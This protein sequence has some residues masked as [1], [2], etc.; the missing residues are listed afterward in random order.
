LG[1]SLGL[2]DTVWAFRLALFLQELAFLCGSYLLCRRLF[3]HRAATLFVCIGAIFTVAWHYQ[4]YWSFHVYYLMPFVILFLLRFADGHDVRWLWSA[5]IVFV[6]SLAGNLAYIAP[7]SM[8][9]YLVFGIGL[10]LFL[11]LRR[12][13]LVMKTRS[14]L[15]PMSLCL[16]GLLLLMLWSYLDYAKHSFDGMQ[17]YTNDRG[18]DGRV[19]LDTFLNYGRFFGIKKLWEFI[20]AAPSTDDWSLY[21]GII[22]LVFLAYAIA[23]G[24]KHACFRALIVVSAL[25]ICFSLSSLT[26]IAPVLYYSIPQMSAFRHIAYVLPFIKIPLLLASGFGVDSFI[27]QLASRETSQNDR[28]MKDA[29]W[30]SPAWIGAVF[31]G[32]ILYF[33][34]LVYKDVFPYVAT[35][36]PYDFHQVAL[37]FLVGLLFFLWRPRLQSAA[38]ALLLFYLLEVAS[39]QFSLL[40]S[41][42]LPGMRKPLVPAQATSTAEWLSQQTTA[43]R[44]LFH[45]QPYAF[46]D[47]RIDRE[48]ANGFN[49]YLQL[50]PYWGINDFLSAFNVDLVKE[51]YMPN[52]LTLN[53]DRFLRSR[54]QIPLDKALVSPGVIDASTYITQLAKDT[55]A[56]AAIGYNVPKLY[57]A[58]PVFTSSIEDASKYIANTGDIYHHPI[59]LNADVQDMRDSFDGQISSH[60]ECKRFTM[61]SIDVSVDITS[62]HKR[63]SWLIYLDN[64]AAGW[65]A[66]VNGQCKKIAQANI[67]F[68]G[69]KL[70]EGHND[71][72]FTFSGNTWRSRFYPLVFCSTG[73]LSSLAII[74]LSIIIL[75]PSSTIKRRFCNDRDL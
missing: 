11:P 2:R 60:I 40:W 39:F 37:L 23:N 17:L 42:S 52:F 27:T 31:L 48:A 9:F 14:A 8:V 12:G 15:R 73:M 13:S 5:G 25:I 35:A 53:F 71:V 62:D 44:A 68:K 36:L 32:V 28:H 18:P 74:V 4:V 34:T 3:T 65:K 45:V 30:A 1:G 16:L 33:D 61:N 66:T 24:I 58:N 10:F 64:F 50:L 57:V 46:Q 63:G 19:T 21:F 75:I 6:L 69:V 29:K 38:G 67:G 70:T 59:M 47:R 20:Y 72:C 43:A 51:S 55:N 22:P 56:M 41:A 26:I 49:Q 7:V 54:L